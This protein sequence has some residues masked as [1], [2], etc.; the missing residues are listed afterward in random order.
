MASFIKGLDANHLVAVGDEGFFNRI[1][2]DWAYA[3]EGGVDHEALLA[4]PSI[5]YGTFHCYPDHWGQ[6][7]GWSTQWII[8]HCAAATTAGKPTVL[9]EYG[10]KIPEQSEAD[11]MSAYAQWNNALRANGGDGSWFWM[12]AGFDPSGPGLRYPDYDHF[13]VYRDGAFWQPGDATIDD[14]DV[15]ASQAFQLLGLDNRAPIA[16][17]SAVASAV[18]LTAICDGSLSSDPDG[19]SLTYAWTFG[20]GGVATGVAPH[21]LYAASG[22]YL[23]AVTVSDPYGVIDSDSQ[24]VTIATIGGGGGGGTS[25]GGADGG[26]GC[27]LG[28]GVAL[29]M[30]VI[31]VMRLHQ[32]RSST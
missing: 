18:S 15:L 17:A 28:A 7:I 2:A 21:H 14:D 12:L 9:G 24:T 31:G 13:T 30:S 1:S 26:G 23:V 4:L 25:S 10:V 22:T 29:L 32:R 16:V 8:D 3:G 27:G 5:D 6:T 20:D 11:R 19:Q